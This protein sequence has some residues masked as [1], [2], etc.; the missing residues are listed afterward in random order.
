MSNSSILLFHYAF[1]VILKFVL[2]PSQGKISD[3]DIQ[4]IAHD[5]G[6]SFTL[7]EIQ[8]MVKSA[9]INGKKYFHFNCG[10]GSIVACFLF[11]FLSTIIALLVTFFDV[12]HRRFEQLLFS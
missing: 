5:L 6:E 1:R 9:D 8:A 7:D 3:V 10:G 4:R 11:S 2:D 12:T